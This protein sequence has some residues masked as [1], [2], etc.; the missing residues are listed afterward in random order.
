M[1]IVVKLAGQ[2]VSLSY[3]SKSERHC[4]RCHHYRRRRRHYRRRRHQ[5]RHMRQGVPRTRARG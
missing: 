4:R 3:R 1:G 2:R 5:M